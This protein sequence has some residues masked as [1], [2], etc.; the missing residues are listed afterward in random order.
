MGDPSFAPIAI[1]GQGCVLP[2]CFTPSGL[3]AAIRDGRSLL[4][5]PTSHVW[6]LHPDD[7][8]RQP[9]KAGGFIQGFDKRFV[10]T[11]HDLGDMDPGDFDPSVKWLLQAGRDAWMDAGGHD[12]LSKRTSVIVANLAYPSRGLTDYASDI[13]TT[14]YSSKPAI[15]RF[16]AG[17]P[18]IALA[19]SL[20][21]QGRRFCLDAACASSLYALKL[22]CDDLHAGWVD[23]VVCAAL[24]GVDN[25]FL[26]QGFA[27]LNAISPT[28]KSRP[29]VEGADGLVPSEGAAAVV[30]RRWSDIQSDENVIGIIRGIGLSNDGRRKGLLV[31][32]GDGQIEAIRRAYSVAQMDPTSDIGLL[33]CHATGTPVGDAVELRASNSVFGVDRR[34]PLP[35][36]SAKSNTGHLITAAGLAGLFKL[37]AAFKYGVVP[38][39]RIEGDPLAVFEEL[40]LQPQAHMEGWPADVPM[41]AGLSTFGFGGNNAHLI[42]EAPGMTPQH[43][44]HVVKTVEPKDPIVVCGVGVTAGPDRGIRAVVR[45]LMRARDKSLN[46]ADNV[47]LD[48][49]SARAPPADLKRA[50]A[51]QLAVLDVTHEA[52]QGIKAVASER[53]GCIVAMNCA[54]DA[55]R[56]MLRERLRARLSDLDLDPCSNTESLKD[57]IAPKGQAADV[58]G[59]MPNMPAN[60]LNVSHDWRGLGFT[61][62]SEQS[63]GAD[64]LHIATTALK[65]R[66]LDM[67]IVAGAEFASDL[68]HQSAI[69]EVWPETPEGGDGA[70]ALVLKRRSRAQA[71]NDPILFELPSD[72]PAYDDEP[73]VRDTNALVQMYG[74]CH[75]VGQLLALALEAALRHRGLTLAKHGVAPHITT[76]GQRNGNRVPSPDI[77]RGG[78]SLFWCAADQPAALIAKLRA[79]ASGGSGQHRVALVQPT[80]GTLESLRLQAADSLEING[81]AALESVY[82]SNEADL[83]GETAFVFTGSASAYPQAGRG[84]FMGFPELAE[85]LP[86]RAPHIDILTPI[87]ALPELTPFQ[88]LCCG[89]LTSQ[90]QAVL[91]T[92]WF[93]LKPDA[94]IGLSLGET[95]ALIAFGAWRDAEV[96][97]D[98]IAEGEM[99]ERHL[100]APFDVLPKTWAPDGGAKWE[101]WQIS[102]PVTA[103]KPLVDQED[104]AD[105]TIIYGPNTCLIGGTPEAC[106]RIADK[107]GPGHAVPTGHDFVIHS[108]M[109][110]PYAGEWHR[111]HSRKTFPVPGVRFYSNG[112]TDAYKPEAAATAN[113]LTQQAKQT[114][115]FPKTIERAY[116]DGVRTFIEIGPRDLLTRSIGEILGRRPHLAVA[117]DRTDRSDVLQLTHAMAALYAAGHDIPMG[118]LADRLEAIDTA[119][120]PA[121]R[122]GPTLLRIPAHKKPIEPIVRS[123]MQNRN[124]SRPAPSPDDSGAERQ[125]RTDLDTISPAP[126]QP[127]ISTTELLAGTSGSHGRP[128]S[129]RPT[130]AQLDHNRRN[131]SNPPRTSNRQPAR[132]VKTITRPATHKKGAPK[133]LQ[134]TSK[135][136]PRFERDA[137]EA[138]ARGPIS[139]LFGTHFEEQDRYVRQVRLPA[140]PLL[141]VD[142]IKG[143]DAKPLQAGHGTIW[144]ETDIAPNAWYLHGC[145]MRPG[146][147]IE[148][149]QAD[150]SLISY[151]GADLENRNERVYRLLGCEFTFQNGPMPQPGD[152]L[153]YQIEITGHANSGDIRMFFFQYDCYIGDRLLLSVRHGQAG[154]FT[155]EELS[156][157][158]GILWSAEDAEPPTAEPTPF[159]PQAVST[160]TGFSAGDIDAL[161]SGDAFACFGK[162][163]EACAPQS[164]PA[165][166][167]SRRLS[168]LD[169]VTEF[170]PSGGPWGRGYLKARQV[171]DRSAWFYE[172]HFHNDPC[173]P[174]TL[175]VEGA[176]QALE[177][178]AMAVGLTIERDGFV[179]EPAGELPAKFNCR[180][181]VTPNKDHVVTYEVFIDEIVD[182]DTPIISAALLA[183]SDDLKVFHCERISLVLTRSWPRIQRTQAVSFIGPDGSGQGDHA[184]LLACTDGAPSDAFGDMYAR[185]DRESRVPR[186]PK[187]P[188]HFM[189]EVTHVSVSAG[190]PSAIPEAT[191]RYDIDPAA[192]FVRESGTGALPFAAIS[193]ILLQPCGWLASHCGF[194]LRGDT[195]FR[196]LDGDLTLHK[197][198]TPD[199]GPLKVRTR[200]VQSSKA[201]PMTLV[202]FAVGAEDLTGA[203]VANLDTSFGFFNKA[204]FEKQAGV[205]V[206]PSLKQILNR[207]TD[208]EHSLEGADYLPCGRLKMIDRIDHFDPDGG[209]NA[210]GIALGHQT[211]DP[212]AWYFKAHFFQDPVQPGSLGFG[213]LL[214]LLTQAA[215]LKAQSD[216]NHS[217]Q[218]VISPLPGKPLRWK[219]RGQVTP[220]ARTVRTLVDITDWD[221]EADGISVGAN[222]ILACDGM[223][224]YQAEGLSIKIVQK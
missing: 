151:M 10:P 131:N 91:L 99:Y 158:K 214:E 187:K 106:R 66:E 24:N 116:E 31:P 69:S 162:G 22:A 193:E 3:W 105:I 181:Q 21:A 17:F 180:G 174:G 135:T 115:D 155:D 94:A 195:Y 89:V 41:R 29:L 141:L 220:S 208:N 159:H 14:G 56:W 70:A 124:N 78:A 213:A 16:C 168:M 32:D 164:R 98:E 166:L 61:I 45:R 122:Q 25:L 71:D 111:Y 40:D 49:T 186:L 60:R 169:E 73:V 88:D 127:S 128:K 82:L 223:P 52:L 140:P 86:A 46:K 206:D 37:T 119:P 102:A 83:I 81:N 148:A 90:A 139:D 26:H 216:G 57:A 171:V 30:L 47:V 217:V 74:N 114:I 138:A 154:F 215:V 165:T 194:A 149:G 218:G 224:I 64:A 9:F 101:N 209:S 117:I 129:S 178:F 173:M 50:E 93:G 189:S 104:K 192:E 4:T 219:Y 51:Q 198:V 108:P 150:L 15:Q 95:N 97:L 144:T 132:P 80:Q 191:C 2:G 185:F 134:P 62:A 201:G 183:S 199:L 113:A 53:T 160:K 112:R 147:L 23:Q 175:M 177:F 6:G 20:Q 19:M 203:A 85:S 190:D 182:G 205:P 156:R 65:S 133:P 1:V 118:Q 157:S 68:I 137:L 7:H 167:P 161:R 27:A 8:A 84:L 39:T 152:T 103:V 107:L 211:V 58:L 179:F 202:R 222:G 59:A 146:P 34:R 55:A 188:F 172:G 67:A 63:S 200:L 96:L 142:R 42:V 121:P 210:L 36:G 207:P 145:H 38:P 18:A 100:G 196:N 143:I 35:V 120:W 11:E 130:R 92:E 184:S 176:I 197:P 79:G 77:V 28:G 12:R 109:M 44:A 33:E 212:Y 75:S 204:A 126:L 72:I 123:P 43:T 54:P 87:L 76:R 48:P 125:P 5:R 221:N 153:S 13:W 110:A 136:G 163:F 170:D